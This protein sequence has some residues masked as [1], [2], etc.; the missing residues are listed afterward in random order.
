M[1]VYF[2]RVKDYV[3]IGFS[4]KPWERAGTIATGSCLMPLDVS[5]ADKVHL[6]GW[7]PGDRKI[8]REMHRRFLPNYVIGEWFWDDDAYDAL[9]AEHDFGIPWPETSWEVVCAMKEY[10]QI[11]RVKVVEVMDRLRAEE[12][13]DPDSQISQ[14][15]ALAGITDEWIEEQSRRIT[16]ERDA[17]R[18]YWRSQRL[19]RQEIPA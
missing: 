4:A 12:L 8:E 9:I 16:G 17:D 6:L 11:P 10:P 1:S 14:M 3:K 19:E 15:R 7:I 5:Y 18:A 2:A 13:A